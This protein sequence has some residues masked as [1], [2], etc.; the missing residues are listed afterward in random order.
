M[1]LPLNIDWQ[2]ILLHIFNFLILVGGLY[3]LLYKPVKNFMKKK[4]K[5]FSEMDE[6]AKAEKDSAELE[7]QKYLNKLKNAESEI[8][9]MKM[10][11]MQSA[12]KIADEYIEDAKLER[13]QIISNAKTQA[14]TE[15]EKIFR[16]ANSEIE[17]MV[18]EAVDKML[19]K[20]GTDPLDEF[21][22]RAE[23]EDKT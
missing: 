14:E 9:K 21:L 7:K 1:G 11:S 19:V 3:L 8:E 22:D 20:E 10:D 23:K 2:Q 16:K 6:K 12:K 17:V 4:K 5:Y 13:D 18:S 15:K